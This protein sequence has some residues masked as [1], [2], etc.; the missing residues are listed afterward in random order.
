[1]EKIVHGDNI[2]LAREGRSNRC[3]TAG[4]PHTEDLFVRSGYRS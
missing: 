2:D 4:N 3:V 1:M